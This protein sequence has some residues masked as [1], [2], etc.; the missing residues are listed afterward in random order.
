[1]PQANKLVIRS[2]TE[3][4]KLIFVVFHLYFDASFDWFD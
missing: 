1:M 2:Q 4:L 3:F